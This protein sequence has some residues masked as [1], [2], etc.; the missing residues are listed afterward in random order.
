MVKRTHVLCIMDGV[1]HREDVNNNAISKETAP[2]YHSLLEQYPSAL[3]KTDGLSVGLP[4]GQMG[5]SEV[6]HMNLGAGRVIYQDLP[7]INKSIETGEI[8]KNDNLLGFIDKLKTSGGTCH[9]MGLASSGGVHSHEDHMIALAKIVSE[10]GVP[11]MMHFLLDGRDTP[12]EDAIDT[13]PKV[14]EKLS[15]LDGVKMGSM[16]GRYFALDRD[17]RWERVEKAYNLFVSGKGKKVDNIKDALEASYKKDKT[18]EFVEPVTLPDFKAMADGDGVLMAN[19]RTDRAREILTALLDPSFKRFN[20]GEVIN[21]AAALGMVQYSAE[22]AKLLSAIFP[23]KVINNSLGEVLSN[24]GKTQLRIAETEKY[25]HVTFFFNGGRED[26]F[27]GEDRI[28]VNSPKVATYDLKPEMSAVEVTDKLEEAILSRKY[29]FVLVNYANGD[30][31]GHTGVLI[32]AKK[33]VSTLDACLK[34]LVDA[35]K[36]VDGVMILTADHGN[37]EEM[38]DGEKQ[39]AH[40]A[41]TLNPVPVV[42]INDK[43]GKSIKDGKLADVAPTMLS[44]MG[45]EV[46]AE[47]DGDNLLS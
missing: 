27:E 14:V 10:A 8:S 41:H 17:N 40:T 29:D 45:L 22:H 44:L 37:C 24:K 35:V 31:V 39:C 15:A 43:T 30:M 3:L 13:L 26:E 34:E 19:F 47:M 28:L 6:G 4:E 32:A 1:G 23:P 33:A 11:V 2:F 25:A 12:P 18:D 36:E 7:K 9:L 38:Y 21:F 5:N 46:P 16:C 42:L 20:R